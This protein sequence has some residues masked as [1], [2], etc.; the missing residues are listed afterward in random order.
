MTDGTDIEMMQ[1]MD[2]IAYLKARLQAD[3]IRRG[4]LG[5][6]SVAAAVKMQRDAAI[7]SKVTRDMLFALIDGKGQVDEGHHHLSK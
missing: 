2:H 7:W 6:G 1:D 4:G 5:K 3:K